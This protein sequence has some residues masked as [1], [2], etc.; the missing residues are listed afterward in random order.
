M[1]HRSLLSAVIA[2]CITHPVYANSSGAK[3][4]LV[5]AEHFDDQFDVSRYWV[6]EKFDGARAWWNGKNFISRGGNV[7]H[8]PAWFVANL[9]EVV[10]DGELWIGRN[11][12]QQLMQTIRDY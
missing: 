9:P 10:L 6:S 3:P 2:L 5:L 11:K 1:Y 12:F 8:A 4:P 7:Y